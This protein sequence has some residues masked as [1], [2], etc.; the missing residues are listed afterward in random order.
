MEQ[1][2]QKIGTGFINLTE[3][4]FTYG[5][6]G[7][8]LYRNVENLWFQHCITMPHYNV[9][10]TSSD[11]VNETLNYLADTAVDTLPFG[12]AIIENSKTTW[13]QS[14]FQPGWKTFSHKI[15][16][17]SIIANESTAKDLFHKKQRERK[18]WWRKIAQD[19]SR[20]AFTEAKRSKN[21][22]SI[23]IE[24]QFPFGNIVVDTIT[25]NRNV[26]KLFTQDDYSGNSIC[27]SHLVEHITSLDW[28]C[29]ALLCDGVGKSGNFNIHPKLSPYKVTFHA[30]S[31]N[32]DTDY[33][34][35]D[36]NQLIVY[37][38]N[39]LR[40]R[41]LDTILTQDD[42]ATEIY[43]APF[44]VKVDETSLKNGLVKVISKSTTLAETVHITSLAKYLVSR[45]SYSQG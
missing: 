14:F 11:Q 44:I 16:K 39:L 19:P 23:E 29:L 7:K 22:E 34:S 36:A 25:H 41:G 40:A 17:V 8:M 38:N 30:P 45:C 42:R 26:R 24:A 13:N 15:A 4:G 21:R 20:F 35:E 6:Q 28:G 5:P 37:L 10:P 31:T 43:C 12:L 18:V 33:F 3:R 27:D 1:I 32:T 2:L 9:F